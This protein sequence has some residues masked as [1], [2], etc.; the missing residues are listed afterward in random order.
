[1]PQNSQIH[2]EN[3]VQQSYQSVSD[4]STTLCIEGLKKPYFWVI[5]LDINSE[6]FESSA[7]NMRDKNLTNPARAII[8]FPLFN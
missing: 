1:M 2:F 5:L 3:P 6:Q 7:T 4:H 8:W